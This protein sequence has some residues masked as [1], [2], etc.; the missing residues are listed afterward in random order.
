[1]LDTL[2]INMGID[3]LVAKYALTV[4]NYQSVEAAAGLIFETDD[5]GCHRH[6]FIGYK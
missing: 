5:Y 1:M 4:T 2:Y 3:Y 6:P